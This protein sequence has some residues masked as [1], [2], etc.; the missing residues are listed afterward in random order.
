MV[1]KSRRFNGRSAQ[2]EKRVLR[3]LRARVA[4]A[5]RSIGI[6][7]R[8]AQDRSWAFFDYSSRNSASNAAAA[9]RSARS[10][11]PAIAS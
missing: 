11:P 10:R 6:D 2:A 7:A 1:R 4:T 8:T 5:F 9:T 3:A